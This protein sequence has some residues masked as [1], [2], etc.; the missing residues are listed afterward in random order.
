MN[1]LELENIDA[2]SIKDRE[3][4]VTYYKVRQIKLPGSAS[5]YYEIDWMQP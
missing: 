3:T 4:A 1:F 5:D 2:S